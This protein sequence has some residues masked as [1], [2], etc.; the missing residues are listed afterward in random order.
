MRTIIKSSILVLSFL[1]ISTS[2]KKVG[3][4]E[5]ELSISFKTGTGYTS[6][7]A[8]LATGTSVKIGVDASTTKK[9]DPIIKF[10]IS[11]SVNGKGDVTVYSEDLETTA[12]DHD[13]NF[14]ISDTTGAIHTYTFTITN[15]DGLSEH[16]TLTITVQ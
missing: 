7:D 1:A 3:N 8:T 12:Y 11:E 9:K 4:E 2:C 16:Q 14:T 10:N 6:A 5:D 13:Y 15:R